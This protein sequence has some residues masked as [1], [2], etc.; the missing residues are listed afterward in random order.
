MRNALC[1]LLGAAGLWLGFPNPVA[2]LP[3]LALAYPL[4][5]LL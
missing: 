3:L 4:A 5:L 1:I 2:Q